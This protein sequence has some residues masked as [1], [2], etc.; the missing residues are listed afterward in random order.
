MAVTTLVTDIHEESVLLTEVRPLL[1]ELI[2]EDDWLPDAFAEPDPIRYQQYLLHCDALRRFCVVTAVWGPG[3][4]TPVHDHRT[5][6]L[7]GTLRGAELCTRFTLGEG[8][9]PEPIEEPQQ[10]LPGSIAAVSPSIGDIHQ[11]RNA[12]DDQTSVS[13]HVYGADIAS[14]T[15]SSFHPDGTSAPINTPYANSVVPNLWGL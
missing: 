15:R 9:A 10:M 1:A 11:V 14:L 13:V 7:V 12:L 8:G 2:A 5:W 4:G 3:Q 6:G